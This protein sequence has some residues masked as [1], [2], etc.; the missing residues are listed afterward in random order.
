MQK[1]FH[2]MTILHVLYSGLGG[3]GSV[4]F[5]MVNA[6][7]RNEFDFAAIFNGIEPVREEYVKGCATR[8]INYSFIKK[9]PGQHISF[10][11]KLGKAIREK[12]PD[13][14][15]LHGS[16][17][18]GAAWF[19]KKTASKKTKI[20]VR[21]T[22]ALKMKTR[23]EKLS[24]RFSMRLADH[25]V[26]LSNE[27]ARD[28]K[29]AFGKNYKD[30]KISVIPNG[31]D[32]D[33][34]S[35][36]NNNLTTKE[37]IVIGMQ[38]RIVPIKDHLTL[39]RAFAELNKK[40]NVPLKLKIAGDGESKPALEIEVKDLG[41]EDKVIFTGMLNES[42]LASFLQ[43]LD[44]YVHASFGETMSTAIMQAMACG[45]PI[46]A[47]DVEGINN[48]VSDNINGLLVPVRDAQKMAGLL[49]KLVA[50]QTL[51]NSLSHAARDYAERNFSNHQ[52]FESYKKLFY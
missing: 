52:M 16:M 50:D 41:L 46:I 15:F 19:A 5:S 43:G 12:N 36:G 51:R 28:I 30:E 45:L 3:H 47:S 42:E 11:K 27:Y 22:Q 17:A 24:L 49:N 26:F 20:V 7:S 33:F 9:D 25:I 2:Q 8:G 29:N 48:M 14:I 6:D 1:A 40:V 37:G 10:Y 35:P 21:E 44:I 32:L 31:I 18:I 4:F 13:V 34:F 39:L 38:S 23:L